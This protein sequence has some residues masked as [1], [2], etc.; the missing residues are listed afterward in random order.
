MASGVKGVFGKGIFGDWGS[1][2]V[3][4]D[5]AVNPEASCW[6]VWDVRLMVEME[7]LDRATAVEERRLNERAI[8]F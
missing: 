2:W 8:R 7:G 6:E 4:V 3:S 1:S 5:S